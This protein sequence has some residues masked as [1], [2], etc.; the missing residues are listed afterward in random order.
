MDKVFTAKKGITPEEYLKNM[1]DCI[2]ENGKLDI[3]REV[4]DVAFCTAKS[5]EAAT[6]IEKVKLDKSLAEYNS[7]YAF[8]RDILLKIESGVIWNEY[9]PLVGIG[10]YGDRMV[11]YI[12]RID[13][14]RMGKSDVLKSEE[15]YESRFAA[16]YIDTL[17]E[18]SDKETA[19][20]IKTKRA[21]IAALDDLMSKAYEDKLLGKMPEEKP[22]D[23]YSSY[24][25]KEC[26][27]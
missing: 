13:I 4:D 7:L 2:D 5:E 21:R 22:L 12:R 27:L 14:L 26:R 23:E 24:T 11:H 20:A 8:Y 10:V 6:Y 17:A 18:Q 19:K 16:E 9:S 15:E 1:L 25:C 3:A